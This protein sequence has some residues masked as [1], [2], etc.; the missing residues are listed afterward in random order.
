LALVAKGS[1]IFDFLVFIFYLASFS[2]LGLKALNFNNF[3][4][5]LFIVKIKS[6]R[7]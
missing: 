6:S 2:E 1:L 4:T 3:N 5:K 7:I